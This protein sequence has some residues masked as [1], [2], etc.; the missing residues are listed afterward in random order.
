MRTKVPSLL[1]CLKNKMYIPIQIFLIKKPT[2][3]DNL[4]RVYIV[5]V[6]SEKNYNYVLCLWKLSHHRTI[7]L[8][9]EQENKTKTTEF[10]QT[11]DL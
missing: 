5:L 7:L 10:Y 4:F 9:S 1:L 3:T 2:C 8:I 11:K 6:I